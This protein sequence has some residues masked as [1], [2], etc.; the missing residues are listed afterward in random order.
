MGSRFNGFDW[1]FDLKAY[2]VDSKMLVGW[3]HDSNEE[4][5]ESIADRRPGS[6]GRTRDRV[7]FEGNLKKGIESS[8]Y[9]W[10]SKIFSHPWYQK[11][12]VI[13]LQI[14]HDG[15]LDF[16]SIERIIQEKPTVWTWHDPWQM[17]GHCIY[18]MDCPR[19][20]KGCGD[21]PDLL[22]PFKI[23]VDRTKEMRIAKKKLVEKD[24]VLHVASQWFAD[25][26][27]TDKIASAP[28]PDVLPFGLKSSWAG[29]TTKKLSRESLGIA[30]RNFVIGLRSVDEP[31]KNVEI[32]RSALR[33]LPGNLNLTVLTIQNLGKFKEFEQEYQI[34]EIPWTNDNELIA[35]YFS[36]MDLFIMP[37]LWETYG[38]MALEA[39]SYGIPVAGFDGTA[40]S[41]VCALPSNG[42][43]IQENTGYSLA[44][45]IEYAI[46]DQINLKK[47]ADLSQKFVLETRNYSTFLENLRGLYTDAIERF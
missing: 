20:A 17:T 1:H 23:E 10:A 42:F 47:K 30:D 21:C 22:R 38:F 2:G 35:K 44:K 4:W 7:I 34:V 8:P 16:K 11:A 13:H 32:V 12:D 6:F 3:N 29:K 43:I 37:S 46:A 36:A 24:Y 27:S 14:V 18:P 33:N 31:Q 26:I 19:W 28:I 5:V 25:F 15:T 41:E 40:T 45:T 39:M 9:P